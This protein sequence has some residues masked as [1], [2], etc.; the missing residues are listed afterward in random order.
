MGLL[1]AILVAAAS[2]AV[3]G[4]R[5]AAP[6]S[7]DSV[8]ASAA[9]SARVSAIRAAQQGRLAKERSKADKSLAKR[10]G[11]FGTLLAA[12]GQDEAW[13]SGEIVARLTRKDADGFV[14]GESHSEPLEIAAGLRFLKDA[15]DAGVVF[16]E[17]VR[18][19]NTFTGEALM[20]SRGVPVTTFRTPFSPAP[21]LK[22]ALASSKPGLVAAYAGHAHTATV[23]KDYILKTL[24]MRK[25]LHLPDMPTIEDAYESTGRSPLIVALIAE[26]SMLGRVERLFIREL[27]AEK[28]TLEET[29]VR[30]EALRSAW[31]YRVPQGAPA[32]PLRF[33]PFPGEKNL[34]VGLRAASR[35]PEELDALIEVMST[36]SATLWA[37]SEELSGFECLYSAVGRPNAAPLVTYTVVL[38]KGGSEYR[39]ELPRPGV[40]PA[41][42]RARRG[43]F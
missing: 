17:L 13:M 21:E 36:P 22:A 8:F 24:E 10:L 33:L 29:L 34:F 31:M 4:P 6:V 23:L 19:G 26:D 27:S 28:L 15:M 37:G 3:A 5:S 41:G 9:A 25:I 30:L 16:K 43:I 39:K 38:K 7:L 42:W 20:A 40:A 12:A 14:L 11:H 35:T 1:A 32:L 18:E 2:S